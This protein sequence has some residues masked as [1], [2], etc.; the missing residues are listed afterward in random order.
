MFPFY[1]Y[2]L[3]VSC[4]CPRLFDLPRV[5][6]YSERSSNKHTCFYIINTSIKNQSFFQNFYIQ[7]IQMN[8]DISFIPD[9]PSGP[10]DF[11]RKKAKFNWKHLRLVFEEYNL[12]KVKVHK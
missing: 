8:P 5:Q 9:L 10:L 11:Y 12:L 4:R 6:L 2:I 7:T 3:T 1:K